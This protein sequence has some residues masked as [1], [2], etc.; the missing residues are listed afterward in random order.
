MCFG[1]GAGGGLVRR[2]FCFCQY[3]WWQDRIRTFNAPLL[4]QVRDTVQLYYRLTERCEE[5]LV[6]MK[7][8]PSLR[9]N[10]V[11]DSARGNCGA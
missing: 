4:E 1:R 7:L 5:T 2:A 10:D 8:N 11:A 9:P 6:R 3:R